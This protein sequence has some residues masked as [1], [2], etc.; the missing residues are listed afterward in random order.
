L[1]CTIHLPS[2]VIMCSVVFV[3][4]CTHTY[5]PIHTHTFRAVKHHIPS[6]VH[7]GVSNE[8]NELDTERKYIITPPPVGGRGIVIDR[9]LSLFVCLFLCLF[10]CQQHYEKTTGPICMKFSGKVWSDHGTTCLNF[11]SIRVNGSAGQRSIIWFDCGLLAVLCCHLANE[12]VMKLLFLAFRY[13]AA[14]WRGLLCL[15]PQLVI[16]IIMF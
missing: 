3:L 2:L 12:N 11:G 9:F 1:S 14:R 7:V 4:E 6:G 5:T 15:A 8:T 13:V 16:I 10:L